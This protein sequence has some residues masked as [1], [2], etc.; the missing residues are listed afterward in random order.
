MAIATGLRKGL[1]AMSESNIKRLLREHSDDA[2][3]GIYRTLS[4][5]AKSARHGSWEA[6]RLAEVREELKRRKMVV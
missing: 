4:C 5:S 1:Q 3:K 6:R 2:I